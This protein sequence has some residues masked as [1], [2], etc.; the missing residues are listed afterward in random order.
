MKQTDT[1]VE[2][3]HINAADLVMLKSR[4]IKKK[5]VLFCKNVRT[6]MHNLVSECKTTHKITIFQL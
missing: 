4:L 6:V 3:G 2:Q 5:V 1:R